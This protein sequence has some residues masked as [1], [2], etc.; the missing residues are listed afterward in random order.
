M[1]WSFLLVGIIAL[2]IVSGMMY[3]EVGTD[4]G[5]RESALLT[6]LFG[7]EIVTGVLGAVTLALSRRN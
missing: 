3:A 7:A 6:I 1:I 5:L 2:F 4:D